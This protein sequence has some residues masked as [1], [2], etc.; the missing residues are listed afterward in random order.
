MLAGKYS[1]VGVITHPQ[2]SLDKSE[3]F[4]TFSLRVGSHAVQELS[5][6]SGFALLCIESR[7]KEN[8]RRKGRHMSA[9]GIRQVITWRQFGTR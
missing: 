8:M 2:L 1:I 7:R 6:S 9:K 4:R 5:P 3:D